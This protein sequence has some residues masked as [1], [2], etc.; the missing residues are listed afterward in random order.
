MAINSFLF[1]SFGNIVLGI[2]NAHAVKKF[3]VPK[4][5]RADICFVLDI[6][7]FSCLAVRDNDGYNCQIIFA[8]EVEVALVMSRATENRACSVIHQY[9]V[10]HIKRNAGI[11]VKRMFYFNAGVVTAFFGTLNDFFTRSQ[12]LAFCDELSQTSILRSEF[13]GQ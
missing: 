2:F 12:A 10:R 9:K 1:Q 7:P 5:S 8:G 11:I 4:F 6:E 13:C 3:G